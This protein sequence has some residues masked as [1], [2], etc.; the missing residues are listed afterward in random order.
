MKAIFIFD[1]KSYFKRWGFYAILLLIIASGILGGANARFSISDNI[2]DNSPYQ[3]SFITTLISLTTLFFSTLFASQLLFREA[4][5]RFELLL[6]SMPVKR[7]QFVAGRYASL[8]VMSFLCVLLL[9]INFFI[10]HAMNASSAKST[11]FVLSWYLYPIILFVFINTVFT[12]AVLS[13]VAWFSRNKLLV[14]VSGL[15]LY[16]FYMVALIYSGSPLMAQSMPQSDRA[17]LIAAILDPFGFSAFFYQTANWSVLQRNTDVVSLS[18]IFLINRLAIVLISAGLIFFCLKRFSLIKITRHKKT[19]SIIAARQNTTGAAYKTAKTAHHFFAHIRA[20]LSFT[21]MD[22]IYILKSIPF[23]LTAIALLFFVGMEMYAEIEKGIRIPQK[24]ASSGL[25]VS[26]IIQNFHALCM[27]AVLYYAHEIFWRSRNVNFNLI[28]DTAAN[29]KTHFI[30]KC[31][32]LTIVIFLFSCLVIIEGILFQL[33]YQYPVIMWRVYAYVFLFNTF[34]LVLLSILVLLIQKLIRLK[35][36]GL[37]LT[38]LFAAIMATSLGK[39]VVVSPLARFLQPFNGNY[40][41]MNGFGTYPSAYAE[42]LL[43]G[44]G[45]VAMLS[46]VFNLSKRKLLNWPVITV[47]IISA[48]I[49]YY[50]GLNLMNGYQPKTENS[51]LQAQATYERSYR[52]Y[53][54]LP[55]PTIIAVTTT[56]DLFPEK[57]AYH[58]SGLYIVANKTKQHINIILV[59]FGDELTINRAAFINGAETI[60][61]KKQYQLVQLKKALLP[62]QEARLEF[63]I[64]YEWKAVNGHRSFNAIVQNGSF[65]RISRYYPQFGYLSA[66]EIQDELKRKQLHLGNITPVK[67]FDAPMTPN[68]D[69]INLDMTISTPSTQ[70]A[71]GVGELTKQWKDK[72]RNYFQYK[73]SSPIPFRFALSS[74]QYAVK[75]ETYKGKSFEIYYHP[76]HYEN[77]AHLLKN[78]KLTMDYCEANFGSCPFNTIRFAEISSFTKGFA[79]TAYPATV[80]MAEDMLFHANIKAGE[81]Q[82]VI[83]ELAG[84]EL[85]HLWWGNNQISPDE[86]DGAAMLTETFAMYTEMMLLKKM[87][88]KEKLREKIK[89]HLGIYLSERG[90]ADEQ[91]LSKVKSESTHISYSKGAVIM[92]QLSELIGEEKVNLALKNFLMKNKYPN[93]KPVTADFLKE[94]YP[95]TDARLHPGIE[96]M[97][98]RTGGLQELDL[99]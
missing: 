89:I 21:K 71:I 81:Q 41:D 54:N 96:A 33:L 38:A 9:I 8:F 84:H 69:F 19:A 86:R 63:D 42:R 10:G 22:L 62:G 13:F 4:D 29:I 48:A 12:T 5:A 25:M 53:Q 64:S 97:F 65:M 55:Q 28:E 17:Q 7:S 59:N 14:Y 6:F 99:K 70:T 26:T 61:L 15:L 20:L 49:T 36:A 37:G 94:L 73:T 46:I 24:Y 85:S 23:V 80:Y 93:P 95:L 44:L 72:H 75:K 91:P 67:A 56:I 45:I 68:D 83:N 47:T 40:S 50:A 30:A 88:G 74:A 3:I 39:K 1:I 51:G 92:Y 82:D 57:N 16:I 66:N 27:I 77:V 78:A 76:S 87:Y 34:P 60:A 32:S 52:K 98:M 79:A 90:Y 35:Y 11:G 43:F 31:L 2:F 58:I 18:G